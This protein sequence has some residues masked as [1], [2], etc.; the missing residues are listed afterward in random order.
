MKQNLNIL[1]IET[2]NK[3]WDELNHEFFRLVILQEIFIELITI[4]FNLI[5]SN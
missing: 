2:K 4:D 1:I 5:G 3:F